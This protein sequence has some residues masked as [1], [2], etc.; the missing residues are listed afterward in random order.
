MNFSNMGTFHQI[1]YISKFRRPHKIYVTTDNIEKILVVSLTLL[2][3]LVALSLLFGIKNYAIIVLRV[4]SSHLVHI[5]PLTFSPYQIHRSNPT[6]ITGID[7]NNAKL[8]E[9]GQQHVRLYIF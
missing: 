7:T 4:T 5:I 9:Y 6:G 8:N 3:K 1:K 2:S